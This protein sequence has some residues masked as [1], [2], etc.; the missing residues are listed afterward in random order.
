MHFY[1]PDR[2]LLSASIRKGMKLSVM[3]IALGTPSI[4]TFLLLPPNNILF[5]QQ[6]SNNVS[7]NRQD[8]LTL[9]KQHLPS[10]LKNQIE[11]SKKFNS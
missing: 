1:M 4:G 2:R 7:T 9:R 10:I 6:H 3:F 8:E 11:N 5:L